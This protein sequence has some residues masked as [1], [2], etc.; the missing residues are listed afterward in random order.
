[1][2]K[3]P[4]S[5][6]KVLDGGYPP[7]LLARGSNAE[8]FLVEEGG[9]LSSYELS[10]K[11]E[12][13]R[14]TEIKDLTF[15]PS[16]MGVKREG[17]YYLLYM[18]STA[19]P[20]EREWYLLILD[21]DYQELSFFKEKAHLLEPFDIDVLLLHETIHLFTVEGRDQG[22][23]WRRYSLSGEKI[24]DA[25][26]LSKHLHLGVPRVVRGDEDTFYLTWRR[27]HRYHGLLCY[28]IFKKGEFIEK[29][30][31]GAFP[32]LYIIGLSTRPLIEEVGPSL[33]PREG[34][35]FWVAW[36][37]A[38]YEDFREQS[39]IEVLEVGP[40][41]ER[42]TS[43]TIK[44]EEEFALFPSLFMDREGGLHLAWEEMV[45]GNFDVYY[46]PLGEGIVEPERL[47]WSYS[48]Y[49]LIRGVAVGED[50][51]FAGRKHTKEGDRIWYISSSSPQKIGLRNWGIFG[52]TLFEK[53]GEFFLSFVSLF[54]PLLLYLG[55][56]WPLFIILLLLLL[57]LGWQEILYQVPVQ[58]LLPGILGVLLLCSNLFSISTPS[59]FLDRGSESL[60][61]YSQILSSLL[62]LLYSRSFSHE[63]LDE[64]TYLGLG[65]LWFLFAGMIEL[66]WQAG[67]VLT[68]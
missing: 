16:Y 50:Q 2:D 12:V 35:G 44:G 17:S 62:V 22:L 14:V 63:V 29:G 48:H 31:L 67:F 11:G 39:F 64:V 56:Q 41:G 33:V 47:T 3:T 58:V 5:V 45:R 43:Y 40:K 28:G 13:E 25:T 66:F 42:L 53:L 18:V 57:L 32:Y 55:M 23:Y 4:L 34:G 10:L 60:G 21:E 36:T 7:A 37:C 54:I 20:G 1:M 26:I 6:A 65:F 68:P 52:E 49:R 46:S 51:V 24:G 27:S 61:F 38:Y 15:Q 9:R 8:I 19:P 59:L 30:E